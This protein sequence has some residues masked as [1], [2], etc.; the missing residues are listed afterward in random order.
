MFYFLTFTDCLQIFIYGSNACDLKP[1][2]LP[3]PK[4]VRKI[5]RLLKFPQGEGE[6]AYQGEQYTEDYDAEPETE[7]VP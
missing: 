4:I 1:V 5:S 2:V 6:P 3:A 7:Q